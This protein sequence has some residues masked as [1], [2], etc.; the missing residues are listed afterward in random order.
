M[1]AK[2]ETAQRCRITPPWR[3]WSLQGVYSHQRSRQQ[4]GAAGESTVPVARNWH[5]GYDG[6]EVGPLSD[7]ERSEEVRPPSANRETGLASH[8]KGGRKGRA[9]DAYNA[10]GIT[11]G[12]GC[13][14]RAG[15]SGDGGTAAGRRARDKPA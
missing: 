5:L 12:D 10:D 8:Q 2:I 6:Q 13:A 7:P 3:T 15:L 9:N 4:D 14:G 11:M 1:P